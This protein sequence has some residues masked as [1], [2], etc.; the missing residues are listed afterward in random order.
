MNRIGPMDPCP[1]GSGKR[2]GRCCGAASMVISTPQ[3]RQQRQ[4]PLGHYVGAVTLCKECGREKLAR[5]GQALV[6]FCSTSCF[7]S[8]PRGACAQMPMGDLVRLVAQRRTPEQAHKLKTRADLEREAIA[9]LLAEEGDF[10]DVNPQ[11]DPNGSYVSCLIGTRRWADRQPYPKDLIEPEGEAPPPMAL[12]AWRAYVLSKGGGAGH[13]GKRALPFEVAQKL[14]RDVVRELPAPALA[15]FAGHLGT[16]PI[17][18]GTIR[19]LGV[20]AA[21]KAYA[22]TYPEA[23]PRVLGKGDDEG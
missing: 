5:P 20:P 17:A 21:I 23:A 1:C 12:G 3:E 18:E 14:A 10:L 22:L 9:I 11:P 15:A 8:Y 16:G 4:R 19:A 7:E 6:I 13:L 2:H